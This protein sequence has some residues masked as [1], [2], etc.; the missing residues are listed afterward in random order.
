MAGWNSRRWITPAL[1]VTPVA[2]ITELRTIQFDAPEAY[3]LYMRWRPWQ[4]QDLDIH[5]G[6]IPPTFGA[7][8]RR[9]Y[10]TDNPLI[11]MPL[12]Y[13]YLTAA[14]NDAVP[15]TT[16]ELARMREEGEIALI[17]HRYGVLPPDETN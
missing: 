9:L 5:A 6:R 12:G 16:A 8:S 10:V 14:R 7:F 17:Y 3:A 4:S 1:V 2:V 11:G 13:Q 15:A